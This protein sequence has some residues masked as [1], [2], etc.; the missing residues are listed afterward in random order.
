[1]FSS[2]AVLFY[3]LFATYTD[4]K[5][6]IVPDFLT[7]FMFLLGILYNF[8]LFSQNLLN[9]N[10][11]LSSFFITLVFSLFL[12]RTGGW[13]GGDVKLFLTISIWVPSLSCLFGTCQITPFFTLLLF[14]LS[15][16]L[17]LP[18]AFF[19]TFFI[20]A[21]DANKRK[22]AIKEILPRLY[23]SFLYSPVLFASYLLSKSLLFP[24][25]L[26]LL[27]IYAF[28]PK[29]YK[30]PISLICL[31]FSLTNPLLFIATVLSLAGFSIAVSFYFLS[32]K[33]FRYAK[34]VSDLEEGDIP[35][36]TY[37][38]QKN[39]I[40]PLKQNFKSLLQKA[41]K[42]KLELSPKNVFASAFDADGLSQEQIK[43]FQKKA[44]QKLGPKTI[45]LKKSAPFIP[46]VC[47]AYILLISLGH[48][49]LGALI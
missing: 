11:L 5:E 26:L 42:G 12:Y 8:F 32:K 36:D 7:F 1:M 24:L 23:S 47:A 15:A 9:L 34:K 21:K 20:L 6:R 28:L 2:F 31:F 40:I 38:L 48:L 17:I 33:I 13:A 14:L 22:T 49:I 18:Y 35:A 19:Q 30:K 46:F 10:L 45:E 39:K 44:R 16:V 27:L 29:K 41:I 4:L 37:I 43:E 3:L 25:P